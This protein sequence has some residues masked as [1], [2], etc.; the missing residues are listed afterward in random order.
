MEVTIAQ[1]AEL[2]GATVE[3]NAN[4]KINT[5]GKIEEGRGGELT[6]LANLKYTHYIYTTKATAVLVDEKFIPEGEISATLIKTSNVPAAFAKLLVFYQSMKPTKKGVSSKAE[7]AP[8]AKI[9]EN[10]Y[11][12]HFVVIE[13]GV[14]IGDN[15]MIYPNSYIGD[16]VTVG[17]ETI[18]YSGVNIYSDCRIGAQCILHSGC[19]IGADGFGFAREGETYTKIP[20]I[21]NVVLEDEVEIG[22]NT[23]I[24]RA[25]LGSTLI[26]KNVKLDNLVQIAH[27]VEVGT[28]SACAS[29]VGISGSTKVGSNCI[30]A[31]QV[32]VAGHLKI[33]DNVVLGAQSGV[34]KSIDSNVMMLGSPAVPLMEE[35]KLII[36]RKR[37]PQ[38][39]K[40]VD[41]FKKNSKS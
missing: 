13:E 21:G 28:S 19:V 11:I 39:F 9:G 17:N 40:D 29:Q 30:L 38:L 5:V 3:G 25:A 18:I 1:I 34:T 41:E 32:G 12:G 31:G 33:G 35:K 6:F 10:V 23:C 27:N 22:A 20:Q 15:V 7:I 8:S 14:V 36:Y 2:L 4:A 37:L 16:N 26:R 24:D